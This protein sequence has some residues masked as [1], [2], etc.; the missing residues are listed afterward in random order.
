MRRRSLQPDGTWQREETHLAVGR[1]NDQWFAVDDPQ[2][3]QDA[4]VRLGIRGGEL[5]IDRLA[6]LQQARTPEACLQHRPDSPP[7]P[8]VRLAL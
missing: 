5:V 2:G 3:R 4:G 6:R 8:R 1:T 7:P